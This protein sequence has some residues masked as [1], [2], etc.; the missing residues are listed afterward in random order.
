[1]DEE[2]IV[3]MQMPR[4]F[5]KAKVI[6]WLTALAGGNAGSPATAGI[7]LNILNKNKSTCAYSRVKKV[8]AVRSR[9]VIY[10]SEGLEHNQIYADDPDFDFVMDYI[11]AR[12]GNAKIY[13]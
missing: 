2:R 6:G 8:K 13:R 12:C 3:H 4:Q 7:G 10:V 11:S 9:H 1:M 5:E